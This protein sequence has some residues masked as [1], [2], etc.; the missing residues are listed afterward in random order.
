MS[1][2]HGEHDPARGWY[3]ANTKAWHSDPTKIGQWT[4]RREVS[5]YE[6][7][8]FARSKWATNGKAAFQPVPELDRLLALRDSDRADDRAKY[9]GL[10]SGTRRMQ[11]HDYEAAKASAEGDQ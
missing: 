11:L 9:E 5:E 7:Q 2:Q 10:V 3:S 4:P 6:R 8:E 1:P